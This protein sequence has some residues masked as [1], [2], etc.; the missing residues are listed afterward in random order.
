MTR[1][2]LKKLARR[3]DTVRTLDA[4]MRSWDVAR[5]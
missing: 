1:A 4:L 5:Q 3:W 2:A